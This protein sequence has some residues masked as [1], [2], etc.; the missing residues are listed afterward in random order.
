MP[1][2]FKN[3]V[4]R[5]KILKVVHIDLFSKFNFSG[6]KKMNNNL[7]MIHCMGERR[8]TIFNP[9]PQSPPKA[10]GLTLIAGLFEISLFIW[11]LQ[12]TF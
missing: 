4:Q 10:F 12:D 3:F 2:D 1:V 7:I 6:V 9:A 8:V 11:I 5:K